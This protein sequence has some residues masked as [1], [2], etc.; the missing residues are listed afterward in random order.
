M[1]RNRII[2]GLIILSNFIYT[3]DK[4]WVLLSNRDGIDTYRAVVEKPNIDEF[5]AITT[6]NC[7]LDIIAVVLK[8]FPRYP[9]WMPNCIEA[10]QVET[11]DD[12]N[13]RLYYQHHTPWPVRNRDAVLHVASRLDTIA[14][15]LYISS[16]AVND[17]CFPP[18]NNPVRMLKMEAY[19][20]IQFIDENHTYISYRLLS[21][22]GGYIPANQA[23]RFTENLPYQTLLGLKQM[24]SK[25]EYLQKAEKSQL[26]KTVDKYFI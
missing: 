24:I 5:R 25:P 2:L 4:E 19:W 15:A 17:S 11:I 23:N 22:P 18:S 12:N 16:I 3:Q 20:K 8:D 7:R 14:K 13:L 10:R 1:I 21:D 6:L 9:D 26:K